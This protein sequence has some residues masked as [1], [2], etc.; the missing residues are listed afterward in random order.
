MGRGFGIFMVLE[1]RQSNLT[2]FGNDTRISEYE[3]RKYQF[4]LFWVPVFTW[5]IMM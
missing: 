4:K 3:V 1:R 5:E 2:Q